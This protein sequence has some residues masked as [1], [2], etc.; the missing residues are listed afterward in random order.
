MNWTST[1][2]KNFRYARFILLAIVITLSNFDSYAQTRTYANEVTFSNQVDNP[3]N[4]ANVSITT[5]ARVRSSAGAALG[6]GSYQGELELKFSATVPAGTTSY[7]R[8]N[9]ANPDLLNTLLGGNLGNV[10]SDVV[11]SVV[12]GN[13]YFEAGA[14][15]GTGSANNV[16]SGN[17]SNPF[18]TNSIKLIKDA[19]GFFYVALTPAQPYDR[20]YIKDFTNALVGLGASSYTDVYYAFFGSGTDPCSQAFATGYEG[21]GLTVDLLGLGKAGVTN[22][23]RAID[24]D[25]N[26]FS[27]ISLGALGVLGSIS[28]I[29]YFENLSTAGD[30]INIRLQAAPALLNAGLLNNIQITA[31]NG[32]T[33]VYTSNAASLLNLDLLGLL[34]TGQQ[35][36]IP[37]SPSARFDRVKVTIT[38]LLNASLTQTFNLYSVIRSPGRPSFVAPASNNVSICPGSTTQLFATT[39]SANELLWYEAPTGGTP[40]VTA[41]NAPFTTPVLSTNKTYYVSTRSIAC[42]QESARVPVTVT[43]NPVPDLPVLVTNGQVITSGQMAT[44]QASAGV[45]NTIQWF[46]TATGGVPLATGPTLITPPLTTTTTYYAGTQSAL[47]CN[48]ATRVPVTVTVV[49]GSANPNCNAATSQ[50]S[51][52]TG[53]CL[54]CSVQNP[55]N[56]VDD[57]FTNY[58]NISL[59]IGVAGTGYQRLIFSVPGIATDSIRLDLETPVGLADV[60]ALGGIVVRVMN[61]TNVV[62]TYTLSNSLLDL[63]I[64]GGNRF[65]AK[66]L[67]TGN[68]DRVEVRVNGLASALMNLRI[69]G[70]EVITIPPAAPVA[71]ATGPVCAGSP[72]ILNVSSPSASLIYNWYDVAT[73]GSPI[74]TGT[75]FT[76]PQLTANSTYYVEAANGVCSESARTA[77]NVIV[78]PLPTAP[79]IQAS[80]TNVTPGQSITL[81][82]ASTDPGVTFNWYNAPNATIP[83]FTGATYVTPPINTTTTFYAESVSA[84]GCPSGSRV[85]IT[86]TV[87]GAVLPNPVPC[88]APVSQTNGVAGGI[89]LLAGVVNPGLA[90]DNDTQTSSSLVMP[91]GLLGASVFQRLTFTNLSNIGDTVRVLLSS[92]SKLLSLGVLSSITVSTYNG[93]ASNNDGLLLNNALINLQLLNG[94]TQALVSFVPAQQFNTVEIRLNSGVAGALAS[95]NVNYAQKVIAA[96]TLVVANPSACEGQPTT[97]AVANPINGYTYKLY[98]AS[99]TLITQSTSGSFTIPAITANTSYLLEANTALGCS[100]ARTLINVSVTPLPVQPTLLANNV[101][102]CAGTDVLLTIGN[103]QPG[104]IYTWKTGTTVLQTGAASTYTISNVTA[105][106]TYTVTATNACGIVSAATTATVDLGSPTPPVVTPA[107]TTINNG[108]RAVLTATSTTAGATFTWYDRDPVLP[109]AVLL[110][111]ST[112]GQNGT[113]LTTPLVATTTFWVTSSS[114]ACVSAANSVTVTVSGA[115]ASIDVPCEAAIGE[116]NGTGGLISLLAGVDNAGQASD[117][118]QNSGS[119]LRVPVGVG[120]FVYQRAIFNGPSALGDKVRLKL[121]SPGKLLSVGLLSSIQITTYNGAT[122]NGDTR[123]INNPL[124][125]L[126]LLSGNTEATVE[127]TPTS[128]FDRVELRLN[129]GLIGALTS[130][131]LNYAQRIISLPTVGAATTTACGG[132]P[133]TLSVTN[134][135]ASVTYKW[136]FGT[137]YLTG[138][139]GPVLITDAQVPGTYDYFV[140]ASRNGC[141]SLKTKVTVNVVAIPDAPVAVAGN[142]TSIC[143][144]APVVLAVTP[145]AGVTFN[146]YDAAGNIVAANTASYTTAANLAG[147]TYDYFVE[148]VNG[149]SCTSA[150][151]RTKISITIR[152]TAVSADVI[153]SGAGNAYCSGNAVKLSA[154]STTVVNPVFIWYTDAALANA[155]FTGP[156]FNIPSA[157]A[158]ATYYVTVSGTNKCENTS[159]TARVVNLIINPVPETPILNSSGTNTCSGEATTLSVQNPQIGI[160][161]QWYDAASAGTL[162][163]SGNTYTTG[164]LNSSK[165]FYVQALSPSGCGN[166]SGRVKITVTVATKPMEPA[167][168]ANTVN[169]C[170]GMPAILNISN[171]VAGIT[172]RW[173]SAPIGGIML[174]S[175]NNF[176]TPSVFATTIFYAEANNASCSSAIRTPVTVT[177]G[178]VPLAPVSISGATGLQCSGSGA[179]LTVDN[180]D[181]SVTYR[182]YAQQS[183]GTVLF[184]GNPY[185]VPA[186][187]TTATYYV[188]SI[189]KASGCISIGRTAVTLTVLP[190]LNAPNVTVQSATRNTITFQWNAVTGATA[191][192]V[193]IDNGL[194]WVAPTGGATGTNFTINGLKPDQSVSIR[195][196]AVGQLSCQTSDASTVNTKAE[197]PQ[198]NNVF[199][200]NTF[201]PNGDG[202]N[203]IFYVYGNTITRIKLRVYNQW[204]QFIYESLNLQSGWDGTFRGDLQPNGVYVYYLDA[205]FNDGSKSFKKGTITLLR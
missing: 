111:S 119:S 30:D 18:S 115:P 179:I 106:A 35:A 59:P 38:S 155:V 74:F 52:I 41:Y 171:P 77:V 69:Y 21:T 78:N 93:A 7:I 117:N 123:T 4:A 183:G 178:T 50:E 63:K 20:V 195:V 10:L 125:N 152:T 79:Q 66:F 42:N 200:P 132:T 27:Q 100:S 203:D 43:I 154:S 176:T 87:D 53:I 192:E 109:G 167:V 139:D 202:K 6:I 205:E 99:G 116:E 101:L 108:E 13:R 91:V 84:A 90:I 164:I 47:G 129:S 170:L 19:A 17:S 198:G 104:Y 193:S 161:Y 16:L 187:T 3:A 197:N 55:G 137:T 62:A 165:D 105:A 56:S 98:D 102:A 186:L 65:S 46:A 15:M 68:Y 131:N 34:N 45:G 204:G 121:F 159:A 126:E 118:N 58:T 146:W 145:V 120:S 64:L 14:R 40:V 157:S 2:T 148:A 95:I 107:A 134:P 141:E 177:P 70:A 67:A 168:A 12:L 136:Y 151:P 80:A 194:T 201:T 149:G 9:G 110:S 25:P 32:S 138:K 128:I 150:S 54:L 130:V 160:V 86:I 140:S 172:Y 143:S 89:S 189:N 92:P 182:W 82:A 22:A 153:I 26:N 48:S 158:S 112:N 180:P 1:L 5:F 29:I 72:A 51:G 97:F 75:S 11:G 135:S 36:S 156:V 127:F 133:V 142:P 71:A 57:N 73:A 166:A 49:D 24:A 169:V 184:E 81:N 144:N 191:Y 37:F 175:G 114:G 44:L 147:G 76:T 31:F 190:K 181:A 103:P 163:F 199:V 185:N 88:E 113:F 188:E 124:L 85:Q 8:I 60:T 162:L 96:P 61:G 122:S 39:T 23:E 196:R 173:Y 83:V 94:G 28:Q 33:Q 174:G